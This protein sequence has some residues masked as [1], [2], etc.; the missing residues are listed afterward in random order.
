MPKERRR[1]DERHARRLLETLAPVREPRDDL[2][3]LGKL[4]AWHSE[5]GYGAPEHFRN[6]RPQQCR[7]RQRLR[8]IIDAGQ[9]PATLYLFSE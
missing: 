3:G 4:S 1:P 8:M 7:V 6:R 9:E 2:L 5:R